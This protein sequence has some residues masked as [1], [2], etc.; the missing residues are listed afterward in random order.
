MEK[1]PVKKSLSLRRT[2]KEQSQKKLS[3]GQ[4]GEEAAA[5]STQP[6]TE[7]N[8]SEGIQEEITS[9]SNISPSVWLSG[10]CN[11][12]N[13]CYANS[14]VQ[15]LRFCPHLG[16]K[17]ASLSTL[18]LQQLQQ[19]PAVGEGQEAGPGEGEGCGEDWQMSKGALA[20]HLH[21]VTCLNLCV[22]WWNV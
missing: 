9:T 11:L 6:T 13:T 21:K 20:I 17:V 12:G 18:L 16:S 10:L 3:F 8:P 2:K 22:L 5:S 7:A 14:I 15:V 1:K 19:A 4:K